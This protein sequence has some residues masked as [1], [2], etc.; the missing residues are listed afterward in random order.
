MFQF[1]GCWF[2][3]GCL[4]YRIGS[5]S[6]AWLEQITTKCI[7]QPHFFWPSSKMATQ[8]SSTKS[9]STMRIICQRWNI[10]AYLSTSFQIATHPA[11]AEPRR[12]EA[13]NLQSVQLHGHY[14]IRTPPSKSLQ[15]HLPL[16]NHKLGVLNTI[17]NE[18]LQNWLPSLEQNLW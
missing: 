14:R 12:T 13:W 1:P 11:E 10:Y 17:K 4:P 3:R 18:S 2:C 7:A 15:T 9:L 6:S 8:T 5:C 16:Q